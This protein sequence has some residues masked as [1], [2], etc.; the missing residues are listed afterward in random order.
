MSLCLALKYDNPT[1]PLPMTCVLGLNH[2]GDHRP[3]G[4]SGDVWTTWADEEGAA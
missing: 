4:Y 2:D 1:D 3:A